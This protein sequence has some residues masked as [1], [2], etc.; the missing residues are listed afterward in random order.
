MS[1]ITTVQEVNHPFDEREVCNI[2][3]LWHD[4]YHH[5]NDLPSREYGTIIPCLVR[6]WKLSEEKGVLET[7]LDHYHVKEQCFDNTPI[8][9]INSW[10]YIKDLEPTQEN[11]E[12]FKI[13]ERGDYYYSVIDIK[14]NYDE[15]FEE[16]EEESEHY[17]SIY[18]SFGNYEE[19]L[20]YIGMA[21]VPIE[22]MRW[23]GFNNKIHLFVVRFRNN[24]QTLLVSRNRL[25]LEMAV[26][27]DNK[28]R[29][30]KI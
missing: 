13:E 9:R 11:E 28:T 3:E 8:K 10:C 20:I 16:I 4:L 24:G 2:K 19:D 12:Q 1:Q 23:W 7:I 27:M 17:K 6:R 29:L 21:S 14:D 5:S 15:Y 26:G 30:L 22:D 18:A 25:M